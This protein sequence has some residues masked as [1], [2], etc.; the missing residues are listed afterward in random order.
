MPINKEAL[1]KFTYNKVFVETGTSNGVG[2]EAAYDAGFELLFSI[3][4]YKYK[5]KNCK[6][7]FKDKNN[8]V[9]MCGDSGELIKEILNDINQPITFWLDS[10]YS[11][12]GKYNTKPLADKCPILRE[13][14]CIKNHHIKTHTILIDDIRIFR[15]S[16]DLWNNISEGDILKALKEINKEYN[17][18]YIDGVSTEQ[19]FSNDILVAEVV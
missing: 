13:L 17:F 4:F 19:V 6:N 5:Y 10:H 12:P 9:L 2:L 15:K 11:G 14:E 3:E 7:K 1:T 16:I 8:V 18:Y